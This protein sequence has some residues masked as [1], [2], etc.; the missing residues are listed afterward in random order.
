MKNNSI[1][2]YRRVMS[3]LCLNDEAKHRIARNCAKY[4]T[5]QKIKTG[6]FTVTA[7]KQDKTS[8][9]V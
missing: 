4:S 2:E 1:N 3:S 7:V 8:D 9:R 6:D 5:L